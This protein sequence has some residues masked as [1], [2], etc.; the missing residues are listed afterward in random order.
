MPGPETMEHVLEAWHTNN[1]INLLLI[2]R[3]SEEGLR[4][5]LSTR[6]G[7]D[8]AR[9]FCHMH[10]LRV[11]QLEHRRAKDLAEGLVKFET[12]DSPERERLAAAFQASGDAVATF[13]EDLTTDRGNRRGFRKG[14]ATTLSYLIAHESHHRGSILLTLKQSGHAVDKQTAYGIWDW[15]RL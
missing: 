3:I 13:L 9:Q 11:W 7:R 2:E 6:G 1:R 14:V 5:T 4:C 12:N 8:V 10:N 15:D